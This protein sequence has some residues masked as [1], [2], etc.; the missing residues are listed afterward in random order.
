[1]CYA[2]LIILRVSL[3]LKVHADALD[4]DVD[5]I[6]QGFGNFLASYIAI[7]NKAAAVY[8]TLLLLAIFG[9]CLTLTVF[10][11]KLF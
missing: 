1:M 2:I 11:I 4:H 7:N 10:T 8:I 5:N 6:D 3:Y 9:F